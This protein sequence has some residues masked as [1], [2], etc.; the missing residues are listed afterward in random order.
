MSIEKLINKTGRKIATAGLAGILGLSALGLSPK[1]VYAQQNVKSPSGNIVYVPCTPQQTQQQNASEELSWGEL[2]FIFGGAIPALSNKPE[3]QV[4]GDAL[5]RYGTIESQKGIAREGRSQININQGQQQQPQATQYAPAPGCEWANPEN[6]NDL[7]VRKI[8]E[9]TDLG[10]TLAAKNIID[11]NGNGFWDFDDFIGMTT[12]FSADENVK[13]VLYHPKYGKISKEGVLW[14][15]YYL[16]TGE[17]VG[18]KWRDGNLFSGA[19]GEYSAGDNGLY[20]EYLSVFSSGKKTAKL[21]FTITP[22]AQPSKINQYDL[23]LSTKNDTQPFVSYPW[24]DF[25]K[26]GFVDFPGEL[27]AYGREEFD[28]TERIIFGLYDPKNHGNKRKIKWEI[29]NPQGKM[30]TSDTLETNIGMVLLG[31]VGFNNLTSW[32]IQNGGYGTHKIQWYVNDAP[33]GS[34]SVKIKP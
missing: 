30:S 13:L 21:Q 20:G 5:T 3:A 1:P 10:V 31:D 25:N 14:Q 24:I 29:Y 16:P 6:P 8:F 4:L 34:S 27:P 23:N 33:I 2:A 26:N 18:E 15:L 9:V 12:R 22:P 7:S 17:K 11:A 32:L 28:S 19:L